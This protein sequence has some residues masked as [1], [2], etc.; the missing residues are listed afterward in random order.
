MD[1]PDIRSNL[2][3]NMPTMNLTITQIAEVFSRHEFSK[4]YPYLLDTIRWNLV[5]NEQLEGKE[6]V[7]NACQQ[8]ADY[9]AGVITSFSKF[10]V[11][12]DTDCV[13]IDSTADYVDE[14]QKRTTVASC[15]I[16][17]FVAGKLSEITS[18]TIDLTQPKP[19]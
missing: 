7:V 6:A 9:L 11:I 12:V 18:Y 3:K 2:L 10:R 14:Q 13:V 5:G 15:D 8:S 4:I 1:F 17:V 16:Y 19:L